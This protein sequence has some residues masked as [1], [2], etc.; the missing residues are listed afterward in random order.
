VS[1][2]GIGLIFLANT[3]V[4][5]D[6]QLPVAKWLEGRRRM[7]AYAV[8]GVIW[9]ISWLIVF[10]AGLSLEGPAAAAVFALALSIFAVGECFHGTVKNALT[11][12]L[13]PPGLLG[14]YLALDGVGMV[15]GGAIGRA[16]GG[17][18]LA[19]APNALWLAAAALALAGGAYAL[20]LERFLPPRVRRT[21]RHV[22][23]PAVEPA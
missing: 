9:A 10:A 4:I 6:A 17:F 13:A 16:A 23:T 21:P 14:R 5:V 19:S 18:A 12:D 8:E 11:A 20:V 2:R 3:L 7:A 1:E 22:P 15:V